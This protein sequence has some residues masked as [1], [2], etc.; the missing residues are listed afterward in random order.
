MD[1]FL[2]RV[3]ENTS[4]VSGRLEGA[5][6]GF[7]TP[8]GTTSSPHPINLFPGQLSNLIPPSLRSPPGLVLSCTLPSPFFALLAYA[9]YSIPESFILGG[10]FDTIPL[11]SGK[12]RWHR[13]FPQDQIVWKQ[14]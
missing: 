12:K 9:R 14:S 13:T 8:V 11:W 3:Q 7:C 6:N 1:P 2:K 5:S 4:L 10:Q